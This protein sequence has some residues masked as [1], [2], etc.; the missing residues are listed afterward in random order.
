MAT[1]KTLNTRVQNKCDTSTNWAKATSFVPLKGEIIIYS[2]LGRI[3]VGDGSTVVTTLKFVEEGN[4]ISNTSAGVSAALYTLSTSSTAVNDDDYF[5]SRLSSSGSTHYERKMSTIWT[6]INGKLGSNY[7]AAD[8]GGIITSGDLTVGTSS[9]Y[10]V[11]I[12]NGTIK[13]YDGSTSKG[14]LSGISDSTGTSSTIALSQKGVADNYVALTSA[15]ISAA[16]Y[17]LSGRT[18]AMSDTNY[19][20][21]RVNGSSTYYEQQLSYLWTY[22][23]GKMSD[24]YI[25]SSRITY[26][27]TD[28]TAGSSSLTTGNFYFVYE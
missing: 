14:A 22:I 28:L 23:N 7:I 20:V 18:S 11:T 16:L 27:T 2:D 26:S 1:Q 6:Y 24:S 17:K 9:T 21:M 5:I 10:R 19:L 3:K 15:G 12:T 13:F 8:G 25:P 4:Y